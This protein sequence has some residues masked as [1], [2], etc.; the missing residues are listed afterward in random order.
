M[1]Y[2][3][4]EEAVAWVNQTGYGLTS[5]L[6]SLDDREQ[7]LW[8]RLIRAGNLYI[9]RPTTGAIV[10]RQPFG[11]MGKSALGPGLKAGGPNYVAQ[12]MG[13]GQESAPEDEGPLEDPQLEALRRQLLD[14]QAA[15]LPF[16]TEE[17][18]RIVSALA[19]YERRVG[20]EF[21][22]VHDAFQLIGQDN[23]RSYLPVSH[24]RIRV[25]PED[26][27]FEI[28]ARI[29]A[30]KLAGCR[31]TVS[32]PAGDSGSG[33]AMERLD[34]WTES[35][36][37]AIEFVEE[38]DAELAG[39]IRQRQTDRVRYASRARVPEVIWKA[40]AES[41]LHLAAEPVLGEGRVELLW[42]LH[43]QSL[44]WDYHRYGNLGSR[45]GELRARTL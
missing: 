31:P 10:L 39:V 26:S 28:L 21:G 20:R 15:D 11:G 37:G 27:W 4:L 7:A 41:G 40:A 34:A 19:N 6:E 45:T 18:D 1:R 43:E 14:L 12:L 33:E 23:L 3:K 38:T 24:L 13:F 25:H 17:R 30:A 32:W 36:A 44:S 16:T 9:N 5:G 2:E 35:W 22:R 8:R 29:G 42:Y